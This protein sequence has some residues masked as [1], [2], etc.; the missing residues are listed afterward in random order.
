MAIWS[1]RPYEDIN[2]KLLAEHQ[3]QTTT[4]RGSLHRSRR[5]GRTNV[6]TYSRGRATADARGGRHD[7]PCRPQDRHALGEGRQ[8]N[9]N[10]HA[11][12][13]PALPGDRGP[14]TARGHPAAAFRVAPL[15]HER[16]RTVATGRMMSWLMFAAELVRLIGG[17]VPVGGSSSRKR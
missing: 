7:V 12:G 9:I 2:D 11:G 10:P 15:P 14:C 16:G 4:T 6:R 3:G 17:S 1:C 8:A 5:R 13:A